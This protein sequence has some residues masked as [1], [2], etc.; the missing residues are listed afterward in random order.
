MK[1][2]IIFPNGLSYE[3]R[4]DMTTYILGVY[5]AKIYETL[6]EAE[7]LVVIMMFLSLQIYGVLPQASDCGSPY[8]PDWYVW[9]HAYIETS[10]NILTLLGLVLPI[11]IVQYDDAIVVVENIEHIMHKKKLHLYEATKKKRWKD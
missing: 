6:F 5:L 3:I 9:L 11:G 10:L 1:S 2:V 4:V 7:I 8:F